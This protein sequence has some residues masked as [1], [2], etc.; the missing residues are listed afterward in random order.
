MTITL[1]SDSDF[2]QDISTWDTSKVTNMSYMFYNANAFDQDISGWDT[3]KVTDMSGMLSATSFNNGGK[4]LSLNTSKVTNMS[5]MFYNAN[6]FDQDI[7]GWDTSKVTDMSGMLSATSFNNGGKPLSLNTAQVTN[8]FKMFD[9]A[10]SFNQDI[11]HWDT[12]N[13]TNM[14]NMFDGARSFNQDISDWN[15]HKVTQHTDFNARSALSSDH[16]PHWN[17]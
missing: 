4:P 1:Q 9:G 12:S 6:A 11:S 3:S 16:L 8:M 14:S 15:V 17:S 2:N 5:H 10:R 13:V 7:S